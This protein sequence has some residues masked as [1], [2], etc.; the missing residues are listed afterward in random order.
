MQGP[1]GFPLLGRQRVTLCYSCVSRNILQGGAATGSGPRAVHPD[2]VPSTRVPGCPRPAPRPR[3]PSHVREK[4]CVELS[5]SLG[6][7]QASGFLPGAATT[8]FV[9]LQQIASLPWDSVKPHGIYVAGS[10]DLFQG[11]QV[12][13]YCGS[14]VSVLPTHLVCFV[15][16]PLPRYLLCPRRVSPAYFQGRTHTPRAPVPVLPS[17]CR[18]NTSAGLTSRGPGETAWEPLRPTALPRWPQLLALPAPR[19]SFSQGA[20]TPGPSEPLG[21]RSVPCQGLG[22]P[23]WNIQASVGNS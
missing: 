23:H 17:L 20:S 10:S 14:K 12:F 18:A 2:A 19:C 22:S 11:P 7:T 16:V 5:T 3:L 13:V 4:P 15:H 8:H 9:S 1:T 21:M 6:L